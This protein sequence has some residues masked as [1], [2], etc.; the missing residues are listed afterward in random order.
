[1]LDRV[2]KVLISLLLASILWSH[3]SHYGNIIPIT[4][5]IS[6]EIYHFAAKLGIEA[7]ISKNSNYPLNRSIRCVF[8]D[9]DSSG[10]V[11]LIHPVVHNTSDILS[12]KVHFIS[13]D[14]DTASINVTLDNINN[15]VT[16]FSYN[17]AKKMIYG[18]PINLTSG[19]HVLS[20]LYLSSILP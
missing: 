18:H 15:H 6:C 2:L 8:H 17:K 9:E 7:S 1:M 12:L 13:R 16:V 19:G 5:C 4:T 3:G 11:I 14:S 10:C 20:L